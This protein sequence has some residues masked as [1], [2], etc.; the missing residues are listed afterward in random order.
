MGYSFNIKGVIMGRKQ[1][2]LVFN[3]EELEQVKNAWVIY[4][5]DNKEEKGVTLNTFLRNLILKTT[6]LG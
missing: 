3:Q 5:Q 6:K 2:T 1:I 4:I